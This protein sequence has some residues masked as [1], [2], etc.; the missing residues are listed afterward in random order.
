[1]KFLIYQSQLNKD[2][3]FRFL[4]NTGRQLMRSNSYTSEQGVRKG[5]ENFRQLSKKEKN[6]DINDTDRGN[7]QFELKA[8]NNMTIATSVVFE[9][10]VSLREALRYI[11]SNASSASIEMQRPIP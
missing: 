8:K 6:F 1:M 4:N 10:K 3:Y 5:I 2:Y 7:L 9:S 11:I